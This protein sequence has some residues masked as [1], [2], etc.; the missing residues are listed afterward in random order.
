LVAAMQAA[1]RDIISARYAAF[2]KILNYNAKTLLPQDR[3]DFISEAWFRF[4]RSVRLNLDKWRSGQNDYVL[5][6][7]AK[8]AIKR[9]FHNKKRR[10]EL[11]ERMA[12]KLV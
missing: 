6:S 10:K 8:M 4:F 3:A 12:K 9:M 7:I 1:E 2:V 11:I 5:T